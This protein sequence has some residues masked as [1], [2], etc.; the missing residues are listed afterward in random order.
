[1]AAVLDLELGFVLHGRAYGDTSL[2]VDCLTRNQGR[3]SIYA[4]G[5]KS[6]KKNSVR[7]LL[8][9]FIPVILS[10]K[11]RGGLKTLTSLEAAGGAY[12]LQGRALYCG[13]YLNELLVRLLPEDDSQPDLFDFYA[14]I[15]VELAQHMPEWG[16]APLE[17]RLRSFEWMLLEKSGAAFAL[18]QTQHGEAVV[19]DRHY[20]LVYQRGLEIAEQGVGA[21]SGAALLAFADGKLAQ[22]AHRQEI[23]LFMR[24][25]LRPLLGGKPLVS[26]ALFV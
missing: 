19:A 2:I 1:M 3:Q 7:A 26:R 23:K 17:V 5:A 12:R 15:L 20:S 18:R 10:A 25:V 11:G 13:F 24:K 9:P 8:N 6:K 21:I 16:D 14:D 4:R 22:D